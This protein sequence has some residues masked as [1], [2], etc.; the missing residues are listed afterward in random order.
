MN[1]HEDIV[2]KKIHHYDVFKI[3]VGK[4]A[5]ETSQGLLGYVLDFVQFLFCCTIRFS[6]SP[7][8]LYWGVQIVQ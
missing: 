2:H 3:D 8:N 5:A 4:T 1:M 7:T 6:L